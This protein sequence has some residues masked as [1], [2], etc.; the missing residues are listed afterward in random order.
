MFETKDLQ[1]Q[2]PYLV[3]NII[4]DSGSYKVSL[5]EI[6]NQLFPKNED[7][8]DDRKTIYLTAYYSSINVQ[9]ELDVQTFISTPPYENTLL[10]LIQLR[11]IDSITNIFSVQQK[12]T[13]QQFF[14]KSKNQLIQQQKINQ[15]ITLSG[16]VDQNLSSMLGTDSITVKKGNAK[17]KKVSTML[18]EMIRSISTK[19]WTLGKT[20]EIEKF[21]QDSFFN[22]LSSQSLKQNLRKLN[23]PLSDEIDIFIA[24]F[25][26]LIRDKDLSITVEIN[27]GQTPLY[28]EWNTY[29]GILYQVVSNAVKFNKKNG[30]LKISIIL[31]SR[32]QQGRSMLQTT[33]CDEGEGMT[34]DL[35]YELNTISKRQVKLTQL[36]VYQGKIGFL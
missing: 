12:F 1:N 17:Q 20:I 11:C 5:L 2:D 31:D 22:I 26:N 33:V 4:E 27:T 14:L 24:Q 36:E 25:D 29:F 7:T 9:F 3:E 10:F 15:I 35:K 32:D 34:E 16:V 13:F 28:T 18:L 30:K 21:C 8:K 6:L 19:L 23:T